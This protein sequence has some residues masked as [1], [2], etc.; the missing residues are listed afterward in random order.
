MAGSTLRGPEPH[1]T[2]ANFTLAALGSKEGCFAQLELRELLPVGVRWRQRWRA[3]APATPPAASSTSSC[4][5]RW[6]RAARR[7]SARSRETEK[8]ECDAQLLRPIHLLRTSRRAGDKHR[9][10]KARMDTRIV[11]RIPCHA[12]RNSDGKA[13]R[14]AHTTPNPEHDAASRPLSK[15][16][17]QYHAS[18]KPERQPHLQ[19]RQRET[20]QP[21][22]FQVL[23][24]SSR[25]RS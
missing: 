7:R 23:D 19:F 17:P 9:E 10:A 2:R 5:A 1:L 4:A 12:V 13:L 18:R 8:T 11:L 25:V 6:A 24:R 14:M 15:P 3:R 16:T 21:I 20:I 22:S